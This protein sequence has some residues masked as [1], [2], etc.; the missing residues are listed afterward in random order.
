MKDLIQF[1]KN[2]VSNKGLYVLSSLFLSKFALF[3]AQIIVIR[4]LSKDTF[5][6]V[7]YLLSIVAFFYPIVG[8]GTYQGL[9]RFG[10]TTEDTQ[11]KDN[12]GAYSYQEGIKYQILI[13]LIFIFTCFILARETQDFWIIVVLLSFRL[14]GIF[15]QNI[16][17]SFYRSH[18]ENIIFSKINIAYNVYGSIL[19]IIFTYF[20]G[21]IG[22]LISLAVNTLLII[23]YFDK[24]L[25]QK[26]DHNTFSKKDYWWY[27]ANASFALLISEFVF[28][29]D[30]QIA[31]YYLDAT[32][33]ADYKTLILLPFNLWL[34][35]Q[36]FIQTDFPKLS[37]HFREK[38]YINNY[39]FNY[40]KTFLIIGI[41]VL[42]V[43]Y[44]FK[45]QLVPFIF[46][47]QYQGGAAFF[48]LVSTV[49]FSWFTKTIFTNLLAAIG[50]VKVNIYSGLISVVVLYFCCIY[51]IPN[52]GL[53][54][55][56]ISTCFSIISS[57]IFSVIA[58]FYIYNNVIKIEKN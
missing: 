44:L 27:N 41:I 17:Q 52:Y 32:Q 9:L 57:S 38:S 31:N 21:L 16:L 33:I 42:I 46:G 23:K 18:Y 8:A 6:N 56:V 37:L 20:S 50:K 28:I 54:G 45:D 39:I 36:I 19:T 1:L 47:N 5:G 3:V 14:Y 34:L 35:P 40:S 51:L 22:Y 7:V 49:V 25:N 26:V 53:N 58:F 29:L 15:Y 4:I 10:S 43:S 55:L 11:I 24:R 13:T 2:F 48:W 12:L 30:I